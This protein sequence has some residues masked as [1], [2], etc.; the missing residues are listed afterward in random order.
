MSLENKCLVLFALTVISMI[1]ITALL[2]ITDGGWA[3]PIAMVLCFV[4]LFIVS[5]ILVWVI[6][7]N[8]EPDEL[9]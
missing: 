8:D 2:I 7:R 3:I 4:T 6:T 5:P 9:E 1:I